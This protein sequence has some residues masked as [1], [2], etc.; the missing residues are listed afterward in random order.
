MKG[1]FLMTTEI[2]DPKI[3]EI[4]ERN[5]LDE[6]IL[7]LKLDSA[8]K[9]VFSDE[10]NKWL[11]AFLIDYCTNLGIDYIMKNL[12]YKNNF[13]ATNNLSSK[14]GE[15]DL[16]VQVEDKIINLE[17]NKRVTKTLIRK[18]KFYVT[19]QD[20]M[21]TKMIDSKIID[22]KFIIQIN[23]SDGPR[24]KGTN[25]LMYE[26]TLME[27]NLNIE[28]AYNNIMIYDINLAY[29]KNELYNKVTLS[30]KE[31]RLLIFIEKNKEKLNNLYKGDENMQKVISNLDG[32]GYFKDNNFALLYDHDA[33]NEV[34]FRE[35]IDDYKIKI[36]QLEQFK[37]NMIKSMLE[38]GIDK[39]TI[40][41][42]AK[43]PVEEINKIK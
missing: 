16:I 12:T 23:I 33:L 37:I 40:S 8:F 15:G 11:L 25:R 4:Y 9:K 5:H 2:L 32:I 39:K 28:D 42:I 7:D 10:K 41:E 34:T 31:K 3:R 30:K 18:N 38:K 24:I 17:M 36:E 21:N 14:T 20:S 22:S 35:E 43:M 1:E 19:A 26:V 6:E 13:I 29:L 27:K